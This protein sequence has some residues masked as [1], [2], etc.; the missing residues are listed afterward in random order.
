MPNSNLSAKS[1]K[2]RVVDSNPPPSK[3]IKPERINISPSELPT[4]EPPSVTKELKGHC[5]KLDVFGV[6]SMPESDAVATASADGLRIFALGGDC[7]PQDI[8]KDSVN[9]RPFSLAALGGGVFACGRGGGKLETRLASTSE[10]L[11]TIQVGEEDEDGDWEWVSAIEAFGD[12]RFAVGTDEGRI[13]FFSH[14]GGRD[15]CVRSDNLMAPG[16]RGRTA[17]IYDICSRGDVIVTASKD[18]S[19]AF[20]SASTREQ[21]AAQSHEDPVWC[22]AIL[23][24]Y[25]ATGS[26]DGSIEV[27]LNGKDYP[28]AKVLLGVHNDGVGKLAFVTDELLMSV[29]MDETLAFSSISTGKVVA[30][31]DVGFQIYSA[32]VIP[33]GQIACVGT[34]GAAVLL[35]AP[36]H[37]ADVVKKYA[38]TLCGTSAGKPWNRD[39]VADAPTIRPAKRQ[40]V[41]NDHHVAETFKLE[42]LKAAASDPKA[43]MEMNIE[44]LSRA[45]A[46]AMIG[47]ED[48][49]RQHLPILWKCLKKLFGKLCVNGKAIVEFPSSA[50]LLGLIIDGLKKDDAYEL[51]DGT[52]RLL[53]W[54]FQCFL[55]SLRQQKMQY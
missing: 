33:N 50:E 11:E 26:E 2:K 34:N 28:P 40:C 32:A 18:S 35:S 31:V 5:D 3:P 41:Q 22:A 30:R 48:D 25:I 55:Q 47:F 27:F 51:E 17:A 36:A 15:L 43:L 7:G 38:A 9:V 54:H 6:H 8:C 21:L 14:S 46:G 42:E 19:V 49:S 13:F 4:A 24:R 10:R 29:S 23:E 52:T 44:E 12:D 45:V 39:G 53:E 16:K 20:W 1:S 37:V